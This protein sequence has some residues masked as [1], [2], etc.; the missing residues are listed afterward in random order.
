MLP[1]TYIA[2]L[3]DLEGKFFV[4]IWKACEELKAW[5]HSFPIMHKFSNLLSLLAWWMTL[6]HVQ[7]IYFSQLRLLFWFFYRMDPVSSFPRLCV[8][9]HGCS[10]RP[11]WY[12]TAL[13]TWV[14]R[15]GSKRWLLRH[16]AI[17]LV[18]WFKVGWSCIA[19]YRLGR[20]LLLIC[21]RESC[22]D[23]QTCGNWKISTDCNIATKGRRFEW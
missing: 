23:F 13:S 21:T 15:K 6:R 19:S 1:Y 20:K 3:V 22:I 11:I 7:V 9:S 17:A 4:R 12:N 16:C 18:P 5:L 2:C 14:F 10:L 8:W